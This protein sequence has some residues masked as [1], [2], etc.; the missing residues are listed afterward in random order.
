MPDE[1]VIPPDELRRRAEK[2]FRLAAS[3]PPGPGADQLALMGRDY[4]YMA[5]KLEARVIVTITKAPEEHV[6]ENVMV[7]PRILRSEA[8]TPTL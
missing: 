5:E 8:A 4:I 1:A 3:L 7:G 6:A 2:C